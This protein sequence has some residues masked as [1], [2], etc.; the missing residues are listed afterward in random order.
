VRYCVITVLSCDHSR[1]LFMH[2]RMAYG[3]AGIETFPLCVCVCVCVCACARAHARA[4]ACACARV[5]VLDQRI[6]W[7]EVA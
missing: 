3:I 4:Y 5:R 7:S 1:V 2:V 6:V